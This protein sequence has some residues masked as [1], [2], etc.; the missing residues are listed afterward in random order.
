MTT[1]LAQPRDLGE[2]GIPSVRHREGLR[3]DRIRAGLRRA[4]LT[5]LAVELGAGILALVILV[6]LLPLLVLAFPAYLG[7]EIP[8]WAVVV[9]VLS[10]SI[11]LAALLGASALRMP[12]TLGDIRP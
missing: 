4:A 7:A 2:L 12:V 3:R 8:L 11:P 6:A 9:D 10:I 1:D 5:W